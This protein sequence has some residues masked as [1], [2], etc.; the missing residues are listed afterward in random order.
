[1]GLDKAP[2]PLV[3]ALKD[4]E[5]DVRLLAAWALSEIG[6]PQTVQPVA[7]ALRTETSDKVRQAEFA[8]WFNPGMRRSPC[9][10]G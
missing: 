5:E 7:E 3:A 9:C 4:A 1:M 6:D 10:G 8:P 2:P